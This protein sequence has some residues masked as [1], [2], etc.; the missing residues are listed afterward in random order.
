L[1]LKYKI[2][3]LSTD[4]SILIF[5]IGDAWHTQSQ[6]RSP[7]IVMC[8]VVLLQNCRTFYT[9]YMYRLNEIPEMW[10]PVVTDGVLV[11]KNVTGKW[12]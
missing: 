2:I 11:L 4:V 6:N 5:W 1:T 8:P 12:K 3:V 10:E 7:D 9:G